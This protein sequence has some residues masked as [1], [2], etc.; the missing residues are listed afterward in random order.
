[1]S[2]QADG[3]L[4][5]IPL[6]K[7]RGSPPK[8]RTPRA[9]RLVKQ[10]IAR[11][12]K[13]TFENVKLTPKLNEYMWKDGIEIDIRKVKVKALKDEE[14]GTVRVGLPDEKLVEESTE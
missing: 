6:G 12:M 5:T 11:H 1:M 10:Y 2:E 4:Y 14:T 7:V 8:K 9:I 13:T 3:V